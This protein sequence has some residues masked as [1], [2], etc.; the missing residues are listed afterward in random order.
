MSPAAFHRDGLCSLSLW[1][2]VR[3]RENR[4]DAF[5]ESASSGRIALSERKIR[6]GGGWGN[7]SVGLVGPPLYSWG[8]K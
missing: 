6:E 4:D 3:V 2:R 1:E 5:D 7:W 8:G